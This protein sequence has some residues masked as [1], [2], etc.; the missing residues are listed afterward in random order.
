MKL[1][2][3]GDEWLMSKHDRS[4]K[5]GFVQNIEDLSVNNDNFRKVLYTAKNTQLVMMSI[6]P[7]ESIG[8][9][10][11]PVDQFFKV[12]AGIGKVAINGKISTIEPGSAIVI[13]ANADHNITNTGDEPLQLYTLYSPPQHKDATV[14]ATKDEAENDEEKYD[15]ETTE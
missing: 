8:D 1:K 5:R 15:G 10:K 7:G 14:H 3:I 6:R 9:E 13:P 4:E 11:H 12:E 2:S